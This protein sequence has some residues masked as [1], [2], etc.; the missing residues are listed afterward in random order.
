MCGIIGYIGQR[1]A[2]EVITHA[3]KHL[4]LVDDT[5]WVFKPD[6]MPNLPFMPAL[7]LR[8]KIINPG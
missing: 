2:S 1:R 3:L 6:F 7:T 8:Y 4:D 5:G